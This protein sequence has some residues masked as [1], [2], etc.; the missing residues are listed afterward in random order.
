METQKDVSL[1]STVHNIEMIE[2]ER[3]SEILKILMVVNGCNTSVGGV[4]RI[5][6]LKNY[7]IIKKWGK[8]IIKYLSI[9]VPKQYGTYLLFIQNKGVQKSHLNLD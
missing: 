2:L 7:P 3:G 6:H 5:D 4:G 1:L 8:S 9:F